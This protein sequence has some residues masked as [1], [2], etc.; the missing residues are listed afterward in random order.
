[1]TP[2]IL[3]ALLDIEKQEADLLFRKLVENQF[4]LSKEN[5]M[6][7]INHSHSQNE[8]KRERNLSIAD[9]L[10]IK[11]DY[12]TLL[13]FVSERKEEMQFKM[14]CKKKQALRM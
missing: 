4:L 3:S 2:W 6:F 5:G 12:R 7:I 14:M 11:S 10:D 8:R 13:R 1:M 9:L